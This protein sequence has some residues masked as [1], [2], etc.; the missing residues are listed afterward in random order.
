MLRERLLHSGDRAIL[1]VGQYVGGEYDGAIPGEAQGD[2]LRH[3]HEVVLGAS[4][5]DARVAGQT[6][7]AN[8]LEVSSFDSVRV[9]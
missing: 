4:C 7:E 3:L 8:S 1:H 2:A 5:R 9:P 6:P